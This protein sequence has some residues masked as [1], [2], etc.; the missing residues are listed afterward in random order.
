MI[1]LLN[2]V[3][4]LVSACLECKLIDGEYDGRHRQNDR[5]AGF[6]AHLVWCPGSF[7]LVARRSSGLLVVEASRRDGKVIPGLK[8]HDDHAAEPVE[9]HWSQLV[10]QM[11]SEIRPCS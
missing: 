7:G 9:C 5:H 10:E 6:Q 11:S 4:S 3:S 8:R 2:I 1:P